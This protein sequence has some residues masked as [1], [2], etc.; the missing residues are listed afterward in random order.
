MTARE[1][2]PNRR[3]CKSFNIETAGLCYVATIGRYADGRLAEIFLAARKA[4]C[5]ADT[6][7]RD[8]A[9]TASI[10]LQ[11][12]ADAE[13]IRSALC[14]DAAGHPNGPLGIVLDLLA[15]EK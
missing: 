3:L 11:F 2:L 14:R 12:G 5:V 13:T 6:A 10:A 8:A 9:I 15:A 1:R 4:G 7:A